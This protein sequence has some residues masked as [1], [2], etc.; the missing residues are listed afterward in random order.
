MGFEVVCIQSTNELG[1]VLQ[2]TTQI[3]HHCLWRT[4]AL[5][6]KVLFLNRLTV[7]KKTVEW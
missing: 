6:E 5:K 3:Q 1:E 4:E 2:P 7:F